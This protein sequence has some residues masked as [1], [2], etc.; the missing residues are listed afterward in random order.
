MIGLVTFLVFAA[1]VVGLMCLI[2]YGSQRLVIRLGIN[3]K[4]FTT[5]IIVIVFLIC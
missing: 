4:I 2:G 3:P 5:I 1:S